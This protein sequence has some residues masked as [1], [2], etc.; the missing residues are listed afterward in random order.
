LICL[1]QG[2]GPWNLDVQVIGPQSVEVLQIKG[3]ET[4]K[5][6][7][8]IPIPKEVEK[9]GGSFEIDLGMH[10]HFFFGVIFICFSSH[11][12]R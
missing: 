9:N 6:A 7:I 10:S 2:T 4:S 11:S 1:D 8:K 3:I 5:K 12:E